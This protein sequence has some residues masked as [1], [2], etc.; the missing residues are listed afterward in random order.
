MKEI[1]PTF[2]DELQAAGLTGLPFS[3]HP[4][5]SPMPG[6]NPP[7]PFLFD[8]R[9][10]PEQIAAVEAVYAAHDPAKPPPPPPDPL[11][12]LKAQ[13]QALQAQVQALQAKVP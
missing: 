3:W 10:T 9:M 4:D 5:G 7:S 1:G 6:V 11:G 13:V 12:E 8:Q 2:G